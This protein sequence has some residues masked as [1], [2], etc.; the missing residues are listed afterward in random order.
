MRFAYL[1]RLNKL[2]P[3]CKSERKR[4]S[5]NDYR[6]CGVCNEK[7][8]TRAMASCELFFF[9]G[10]MCCKAPVIQVIKREQ[11]KRNEAKENQNVTVFHFATYRRFIPDVMVCP[12][13]IQNCT[14]SRLE[15]LTYRYLPLDVKSAERHIVS[16]SPSSSFTTI[17]GLSGI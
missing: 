6:A 12:Y 16:S 17:E 5:V 2:S 9:K 15:N 11:V 8:E 4:K 14:E 10:K 7:Q 3:L 13:S 1:K